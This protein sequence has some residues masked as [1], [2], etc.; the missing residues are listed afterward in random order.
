[1]NTTIVV[2]TAANNLTDA[3]IKAAKLLD[4]RSVTQKIADTAVESATALLRGDLTNGAPAIVVAGVGAASVA[5]ATVKGLEAWKWRKLRSKLRGK[6]FSDADESRFFSN[7]KGSFIPVASVLFP[8]YLFGFP[9]A[10]VRVW[11]PI[12]A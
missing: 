9:N 4:R 3:A 1:M 2:T 10:L 6:D 11:G 7:A 8:H 5:Y 12:Q